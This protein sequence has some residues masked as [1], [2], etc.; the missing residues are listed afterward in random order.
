MIGGL[1]ADLSSIA[2]VVNLNSDSIVEAICEKSVRIPL[3]P[4]GL[5]YHRACRNLDPENPPQSLQSASFRR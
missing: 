5:Q 1:R 4:K 2:R 3:Y